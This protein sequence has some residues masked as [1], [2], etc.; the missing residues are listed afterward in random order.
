V[1]GAASR[2]T[3]VRRIDVRAVARVEGSG[4]LRVR[5]AP[6]GTVE[7]AEFAIFEPPRFFE[8]LLVGR[9]VREVPDIVARI[10]GICP[11]AYQLAAC[12]ALEAALGVRLSPAL[13]DLRTLLLCAEWIQSHAVHVFLLHAA[14]Y[15]GLVSGFEIAARLPGFVERG[16]RMK[17]IGCRLLEV[18]GGRAVHPVNVAVGGFHRAPDPAAIRGLVPDLEWGLAAALESLAVVGTFSSPSFPRDYECVAVA[19]TSGYLATG[20]DGDARIVSS[21]GLDI[22]STAF[23]AHFVERQVPHSTGLHCLLEPGGRPYLTGPLARLRLFRDRLPPAAR[24]AADAHVP[25]PCRDMFQSIRV[26]LVEIAAAFE[27]AARIARTCHA[28]VAPC[29]SDVTPRAGTGCHA[30]EAPRGLL[31]HRYEIAADGLV[32]AATIVPPTSQNLARIEADLRAF[33]PT[34]LQ[35]PE[36]EA[37]RR[38]E[39]LIRTYD[40]CISCAAHFLRFAVESPVS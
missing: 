5:V 28:T 9:E 33:V 40:P 7:I 20:T 16:L 36:P 35:F 6:D 27:E 2:S 17:E 29:R 4:S 3:A 14:D 19:P 22:P 1:S 10:C 30:V 34:V 15:L 38:C 13:H 8:R 26:R 18:L 32:A 23:S 25:H 31:W 24:R 12:G 37:A 39:H 11:V 21:S